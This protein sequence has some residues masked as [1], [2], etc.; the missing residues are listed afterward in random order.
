VVTVR[1]FDS[2][3]RPIAEQDV[4]QRGPPRT[5]RVLNCAATKVRSLLTTVRNLHAYA[6]IEHERQGVLLELKN[7]A[8]LGFTFLI[9]SGLRVFRDRSRF[10]A[11]QDYVSAASRIVT[12]TMRPTISASRG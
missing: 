12:Q 9:A 11:T 4:R 5:G 2:D 10:A 6:G 3:I 8:N 1:S 7:A